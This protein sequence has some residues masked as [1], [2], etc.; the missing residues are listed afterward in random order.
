MLNNN[1]HFIWYSQKGTE[2]KKVEK[3]EDKKDS[4]KK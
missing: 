3:K 1:L 2:E 4:K